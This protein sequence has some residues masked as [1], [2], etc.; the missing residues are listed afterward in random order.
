MLRFDFLDLRLLHTD[1]MIVLLL[2]LKEST[3]ANV[4]LLV[5]NDEVVSN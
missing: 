5:S 1:L 3:E 4:E 2:I